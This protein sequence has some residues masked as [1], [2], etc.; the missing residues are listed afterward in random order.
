LDA[1]TGLPKLIAARSFPDGASSLT[2][3]GEGCGVIAGIEH[4]THENAT[5]QAMVQRNQIVST[6]RFIATV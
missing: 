4:A 6:Y 3:A 5:M 1:R 2:V